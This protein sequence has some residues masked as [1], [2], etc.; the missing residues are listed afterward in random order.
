MKRSVAAIIF[1]ITC[2]AGYQL[3]SHGLPKNN[4]GVSADATAG[5]FPLVQSKKAAP[6]FM[7]AKDAEV[8][9]IAAEAL[10]EDVES[11]T[12]IRAEVIDSRS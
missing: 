9:R 10:S 8:V 6:F 7:D 3:Q 5:A 2:L 12:G 4:I 11:I 1:F